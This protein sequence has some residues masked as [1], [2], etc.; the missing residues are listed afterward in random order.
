MVRLMPQ[1]LNNWS[2]KRLRAMYQALQV[3]SQHRVKGLLPK[4]KVLLT[5]ALLALDTEKLIA[6]YISGATPHYLARAYGVCNMTV[7]MRLTE[8][9]LAVRPRGYN[10]R[11]Q[12]RGTR[13]Y[14]IPEA[15]DAS[16]RRRHRV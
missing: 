15:R 10:A 5:V 4:R 9:G 2:S 6:E 16:G 13:G 7:R 12:I 11:D 1:L 3:K 8:S 14:Y